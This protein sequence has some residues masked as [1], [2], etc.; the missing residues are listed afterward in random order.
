MMGLSGGQ[1]VERVRDLIPWEGNPRKITESQA[2]QLRISLDKFGVADIPVV[3]ADGTIV[4]GHQRCAIL[5]AQGKGDMEV[6]VRV[7]SRKL[8][9]EEFAELNLR[10]NK[11]LGEW[12]FDVLANFSEDLLLSVGFDEEEL[13]GRI[14]A[15]PGGGRGAGPGPVLFPHRGTAGGA[16]PEDEAGLLLRHARG[17]RGD[18]GGVR[19]GLGGERTGQGSVHGDRPRDGRAVLKYFSTFT[20]IGGLDVG[21]EELGAECI[22]YSEIKESSVRIYDRHFPGRRNFGDITAIVP[23][24]L[25][26]F[27]LMT[28]GFPCQS[29]SL[30]GQRK[31]FKERG[32][33][34]RGVMIFHLADILE[35]KKPAFA[36]L[37]NVR[38]IVSHDRGRTVKNVVN[39]LASAG[40]FVRIVLLNACH[41]GS[42]QNRERVFFL[43]CRENDFPIKNPEKMDDIEKVPGLPH[44]PRDARL[45]GGRRLDAPEHLET[46][47]RPVAAGGQRR[48]VLIRA[49]R[50]IRQGRDDHDLARRRGAQ[51][52]PREGG[53]AGRGVPVPGHPGGGE[54]A[55]VHRQL[56]GLRNRQGPVVR[57]GQRRELP[58]VQVPVQELPPGRVVVRGDG[59]RA[60]GMSAPKRKRPDDAKLL[61]VIKAKAAVVSYVAEA[62]GVDPRT[63]RRWKERSRKVQ[64]MFD[65][66]RE[67]V[68]DLAEATLIKNI[69][70]GKTADTIFYL[71]CHGKHRGYVE[72]QEITGKD[73]APIAAKVSDEEEQRLRRLSV[74]D[75]KRIRDIMRNGSA[76]G[77]AGQAD[78]GEGDPR[79]Q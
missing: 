37:E 78:G 24:E 64:G 51:P 75:L 65:E 42:A 45:G 29:F 38:G 33:G 21:L 55:G 5:M 49:G 11:N 74:E 48:R 15:V 61:E 22:G 25:P 54:A 63:V 18:Q 36:V 67:S 4:G 8:T 40:Y 39:L 77:S 14:R 47:N 9:D 17:V 53:P 13:H 52:K 31:G 70:A 44:E 27:D 43:C 56:D 7:P 19:E 35:A 41:Y 69:K 34:Q 50:R 26:D 20:G 12:D 58:R 23:E 10:L 30:A 72:R 66:V 59:M 79:V 3:D 76:T 46:G 68:L 71:K 62:C 2:D 57:G 60:P 1:S 73:G 16:A 6:D 32:K 28:G